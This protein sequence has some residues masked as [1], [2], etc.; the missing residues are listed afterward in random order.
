MLD[1]FD[2]INRLWFVDFDTLEKFAY[3]NT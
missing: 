2:L 1:I 3:A